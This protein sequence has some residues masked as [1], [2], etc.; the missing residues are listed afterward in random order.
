MTGSY[1][2]W[3]IAIGGNGD[4]R[5]SS[6]PST[7]GMKP[8]IAS[9]AA[10]RGRPRPSASAYDM[11]QPCENPPRT[12][13]SYGSASR[14]SPSASKLA[15]KCSRVGVGMP[16][17]AYQCAPPGG[18]DS[19]PR[20]V[21]PWSRRSGSS[22]SSSGWRSC[23]SAPRPCRRTRAPSASPAAGRSRNCS[24]RIRQRREDRLD[25]G[26]EV[27]ERG[28]QDQ[29]LAEMLGILVGREARPLRRDLVQHA[30]RLAEVDRAEPEAVDDLGGPAAGCE[31]ALAPLQLV[32]QL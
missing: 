30:A 7:R 6:K 21:Y 10:G 25:L 29:L 17:S 13:R 4:S 28:R 27:L 22:A 5:S 2:P 8:L 9:S 11:T 1:V 14:N 23:S 20:G 16:P 12:M 31:H 18:S 24:T 15:T 26:A 3:T 32:V 19:G